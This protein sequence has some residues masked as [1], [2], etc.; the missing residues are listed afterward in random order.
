MSKKELK[1][2]LISFVFDAL[3]VKCTP[4]KDLVQ[5]SGSFETPCHG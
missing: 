3:H 1:I 2:K 5:Q 4:Q